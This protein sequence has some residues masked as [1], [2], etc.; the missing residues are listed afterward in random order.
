MFDSPFKIKRIAAANSD[1]IESV[2]IVPG[3]CS[4][5]GN[6]PAR[7]ARRRLENDTPS[8]T[9]SSCG[10]ARSACSRFASRLRATARRRGGRYV[11]NDTAF[12]RG[13]VKDVFS[14]D[15]AD[16][17]RFHAG[18]DRQPAPRRHTPVEDQILLQ[19]RFA[20][21]DRPAS[22]DL[23]IDLASTAFNQTT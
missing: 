19:V 2:A 22:T 21:V 9:I 17:D 16:G 14:A 4:S 20:N 15:R 1:L 12:V 10:R 7:L 5:T 6:C 18:K 13:R 23:G 8:P 3:R 11:D